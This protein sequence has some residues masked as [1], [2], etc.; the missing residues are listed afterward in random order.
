MLCNRKAS[1]SVLGL[2]LA[3]YLPIGSVDLGKP[4]TR[5]TGAMGFL[6]NLFTSEPIDPVQLRMERTE[7]GFHYDEIMPELATAT[8]NHAGL[9]EVA[10]TIEKKLRP[11]EAA[12][13]KKKSYIDEQKRIGG[14]IHHHSDHSAFTAPKAKKFFDNA[15]KAEREYKD[16][17]RERQTLS[18]DLNMCRKEIKHLDGKLRKL[19][20]KQQQIEKRHRQIDALLKL[21]QDVV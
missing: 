17:G 1:A 11:L 20:R 8:D 4:T 18:N 21:A 7:L 10:Q 16:M 3:R 2:T 6:S 15:K 12:M 14:E 9:R 5:K 19:R 13:K